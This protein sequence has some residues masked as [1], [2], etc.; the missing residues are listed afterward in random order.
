MIWFAL[1]LFVVSFLI[2]AFLSP[3]PHI[4]DARAN[5]LE[6]DSFPRATENAPIPLV[7]GKVRMKA[8]NT[9]WYGD[10][11]TVPITEKIKTGFFSSKNAIVAY[12]YFIGLDMALCMGPNVHL[13]EIYM[14]G[15]LVWEGDVG[16]DPETA[17]EINAPSVFGGYKE[18]GGWVGTARFYNGSYTQPLNAYMLGLEDVGPTKLSSYP[19]VSHI[20]FEESE[21]GESPALR[22]MAFVISRY[23]DSL[24]L[25]N[26]GLIGDHDI[27]PAEAL[28]LILTDPWAG[29]G[30]STSDIDITALQ[31]VGETLYN[32]DHGCSVLV[33]AETNGRE[34][35]K[36]LL[37]Q[38][39]GL[40]YH[41]PETGKIKPV[42]IRQDYEVGTIPAYDEDEI[43][44]VDNFAKT[45]WDDVVSQTKIVYRQRE[46]ESDAVAISQDAATI[47]MLGNRIKSSTQT[48]PF[49]YNAVTANE[50]ASRERSQLSVPLFRVTL[51][52]NRVVFGLRPG[53]VFK[54]SWSD[55]NISNVVLRVQ[56]FNL[57]AML[58][59]EIIVDCIQDRFA[60][61][62]VIYATPEN[63]QW[64]PP[65]NSPTDV[66]TYEIVEM[67]RYW[68]ARLQEPVVDGRAEGIPLVV[69]PSTI[70]SGMDFL[71]G[72]ETEVLDIRDPQEVAYGATGLLQAAYTREKG[73]ATGKDATGFILDDVQG[74]FPPAPSEFS[75]T[76]GEAGIV[77]MGGEYMSY[78]G[79]TI[80]MDGSVTL[81]NIQRGL[82]GTTIVSHSL[83][84]R[85]YYITLEMLGDGFLNN[86]ADNGELFFKIL[87]RAGPLVQSPE[88]VEEDSKTMIGVADSPLR[89]RLL[90]LDS[91]RTSIEVGPA[92]GDLDLTWLES[93]R[94]AELLAVESSSDETPDQAEL[95]N[96]DVYIDGV[97]NATLSSEGETNPYAVPFS[98]TEITEPNCEFRVW[99][100]RVGGGEEESKHYAWLPFSMANIVEPLSPFWDHTD[101]GFT[102][103][104]S[105]YSLRLRI[106]TYTGPCIR[107][108][109]TN[110][111]SE[112]DVGFD[113][114]T[115]MLDSFSVVGSARVVR[116][117]DQAEAIDLVA[118]SDALEP[119][120]SPTGAPNGGP[121]IDFVGSVYKLDGASFS[122]GAPN[123]HTLAR[124]TWFF[125]AVGDVGTSFRYAFLIPD[126][127]SIWTGLP[128]I[129][130]SFAW[131]PDER[132]QASWSTITTSEIFGPTP[133]TNA[134]VLMDSQ[135]NASEIKYYFSSGVTPA[136]VEASATALSYPNTTAFR[137]GL[138]GGNFEGFGGK[139]MEFAMLDQGISDAAIRTGLLD[140]MDDAWFS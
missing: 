105:V 125:S 10:L 134:M 122:N 117:Y 76:H 53:A 42:L 50:I 60:L 68:G 139:V 65:P 45:S 8:P 22:K 39:D 130:V 23:S 7:I 138:N 29:L 93:N 62:D 44:S 48:F 51:R 18:G 109:D 21:I 3:K 16:D 119:L 2:T 95:Y 87:D 102:D 120:L 32:E 77:Y 59:G 71:I 4:E 20:V 72:V 79:A 40:F 128:Y 36:E 58:N 80:G 1:A 137:M 9:I 103:I 126:K 88:E 115:G 57:G 97:L 34:L 127:L 63:S 136:A 81:D 98:A 5:R 96:I 52:F 27:N 123:A 121:C 99:S 112:Q 37:R 113:T 73:F 129:R 67:P 12:R 89:P 11:I 33:T 90:E 13:H 49:L 35:I 108:R 47:A 56:K 46:A 25:S 61:A 132:I 43:I 101:Y 92:T 55:Y 135:D 91:K 54:F 69:P 41:D 70:S 111:N 75:R 118:P 14:D 104:V 124:P 78:E 107:I 66:V 19:G 140:Q 114:V 30:I 24:S 133:T 6:P 28:H 131:N 110:D 100:Q 94:E 83:G 84:D 26:N 86:L 17:I 64:V 116:W 106:S 31:A 85:L 74:T 38:I 82:F 15:K